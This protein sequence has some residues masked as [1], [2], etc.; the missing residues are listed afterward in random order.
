MNRLTKILSVVAISI[1]LFSCKKDVVTEV[2]RQNESLPSVIMGAKL[3]PE[4]KYA[5][6]PVVNYEAAR[7]STLAP[8]AF[9]LAMPP[10]GNQGS[11]GSCVSWATA[12]A[13]RSGVYAAGTSTNVFSYSTNIFS[14][15]YVYNT[16]IQYTMGDCTVGTTVK[17]ALDLLKIQGV[18]KYNSMPPVAGNC[19]T[20]P[21][22][23]QN[24]EAAQFK[25]SGYG[26]VR[27]TTSAIK[28][29][30]QAGK[31]VVTA[32]PVNSAFRYLASGAVLGSYTSASY[33]GDHCYCIIGY[34][35]TKNAFKF[36][37][38]WG[39]SW[40][41]AGYGWINYNNIGEWVKE[42]YTITN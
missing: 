19:T 36:Q 40:A 3:M 22:A 35:D 28:S 42:A 38:S 39:T 23:T 8:S 11:E 33:L 29:A 30:L 21:N 31:P 5:N 25:I 17:E 9:C 34:D 18:C 2:T 1:A 24:A 13:V 26:T 37:N 16:L 41:S 10:V 15:E 12:Y 4:N 32:G 6:I 7:V 20:L 14:P 27:I